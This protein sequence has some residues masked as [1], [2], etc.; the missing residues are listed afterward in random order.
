MKKLVSQL[1]LVVFITAGVCVAQTANQGA[2]VGTVKDPNGLVVP[3]VTVTINDNLSAPEVSSADVS[4]CTGETGVLAVS[5]PQ[6]NLTYHWYTPPSGGTA[7]HTGVTYTLNN[8]TA[9]PTYYVEAVGA[10]GC[11]SNTRTEVRVTVRSIAVVGDIH[12]NGNIFRSD[13]LGNI[14]V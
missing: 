5:G 8:V 1:I 14:F 11:R 3:S 13:D 12:V 2:V 9:A 6:T 7:V 10:G 4:V